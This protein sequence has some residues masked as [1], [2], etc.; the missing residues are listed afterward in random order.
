MWAAAEEG[1]PAFRL[2]YPD[3]MPLREKIETIAREI[4]GAAG[5]DFT[6]GASKRLADYEA[7][8]YGSLP[9]CM[10]KTHLSLSHEASLKGRPTGFRFPI[11]DVRLSAGAG[12]IYPLAGDMRTMPGLPSHPA[13]ENIDIDANGEVVG[14]F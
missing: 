6:P 3:E 9:V 5:V 13:G 7:L 8:G 12:F 4:Y 10:A 11:R 1:A 2:L 14:L